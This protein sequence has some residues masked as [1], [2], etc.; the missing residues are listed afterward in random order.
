MAVVDGCVLTMSSHGREGE[1]ESISCI[2]SSSYK[3]TDLT[4][5]T[6]STP[7][8]FPQASSPNTIS[9]RTK[10]SMYEFLGKIIQ[11]IT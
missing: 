4:F 5:M 6:S 10:V 3:D 9:L 1:G 11:S 7:K 2:S 8:Y